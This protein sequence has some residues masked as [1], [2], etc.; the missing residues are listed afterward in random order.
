MSSFKWGWIL[1]DQAL[2][3]IFWILLNVFEALKPLA[4]KSH[5]ANDRS[6]VSYSLHIKS[7]LRGY[8]EFRRWRLALLEFW[9]LFSCHLLIWNNCLRANQDV[10]TL[11]TLS[12]NNQRD[13]NCNF[14]LPS[15]QRWQCLI[16]KHTL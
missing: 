2:I 13:F 12:R 5:M 4:L 11:H 6:R 8:I 1:S 14:K 10:H 3:L 9:A 16:H 7:F 15:I